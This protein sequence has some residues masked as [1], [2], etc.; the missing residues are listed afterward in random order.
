MQPKRL[1]RYTALHWLLS[2]LVLFLLGTSMAAQAQQSMRLP[3]AH[4]VSSGSKQAEHCPAAKS[5]CAASVLSCNGPQC[6]DACQLAAAYL[7]PNL[8]APDPV[9]FAAVK[10]WALPPTMAEAMLA[11]PDK[12][13][14]LHTD[15]A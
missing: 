7:L 11:P 5:C 2:G 12:P 13:P 8:P 10:V 3:Q 6:L 9:H 15:R 4:C 1:W 14:Q